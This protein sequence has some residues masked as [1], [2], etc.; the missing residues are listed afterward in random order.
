MKLTI[1]HDVHGRPFWRDAVKDVA[2]TL[3]SSLVITWN[4]I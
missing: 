2:D 1:I 4:H 3:S